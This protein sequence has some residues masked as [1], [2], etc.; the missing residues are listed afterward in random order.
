MKKVGIYFLFSLFFTL[1][2]SWFMYLFVHSLFSEIE[3]K[4]RSIIIKNCSGVAVGKNY[5][6]STSQAN[7]E[8]EKSKGK[9]YPAYHRLLENTFK[10]FFSLKSF[11]FWKQKSLIV[12][13]C[14]YLFWKIITSTYLLNICAVNVCQEFQLRN[15]WN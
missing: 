3:D 9:N 10:R 13:L 6:I 8:L 2:L 11:I 4:G 5:I 14:S 1:S 7:Q 15:I 12:N